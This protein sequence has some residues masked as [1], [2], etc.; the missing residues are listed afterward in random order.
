MPSSDLVSVTTWSLSTA[1][2]WSS[3]TSHTRGMIKVTYHH[4]CQNQFFQSKIGHFSNQ[5]FWS[6]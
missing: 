3:L 2:S 5:Y 4:R 1:P 6:I